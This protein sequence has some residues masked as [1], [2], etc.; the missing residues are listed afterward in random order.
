MLIFVLLSGYLA[1][2][3]TLASSYFSA[4]ATEMEMVLYIFMEYEYRYDIL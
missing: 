1:L 3:F 2:G 4:M